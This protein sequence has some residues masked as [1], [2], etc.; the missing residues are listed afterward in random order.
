MNRLPDPRRFGTGSAHALLESVAAAVAAADL[1]RRARRDALR[2]KLRTLLLAGDE[3]GIRQAFA[4]MPDAAHFRTLFDA[5]AQ[6]VESPQTDAQSVQLRLFAFPLVLV[7]AAAATIRIAGVLPRIADV[8]QLFETSAVLGQMRN[9]GLSAALCSLDALESVSPVMLFAAERA[10]DADAVK[11]HLPPAGLE[12]GAGREQAHLRFL[13]GA[14][15]GR[16]D[17]PEF[18]ETAAN[19][20]AWGRRLGALIAQQLAAPGLQL[21]V[22]PRMPAGLMRVRHA[23]RCAQLDVA[24]HLF[25]SNTV[26]RMRMSAGEPAAILSTHDSGELRLTLSSVF[27]DDLVESFRWP[28][29]PLDDLGAVEQAIVGLLRE[30]RIDDVRVVPSVLPAKRASGGEWHPRVAE[31]DTLVSGAARH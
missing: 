16:A 30:V 6:A 4:A 7:A 23:G 25:V 20:G 27:A 29:A 14:G 2:S 9:F 18:S 19:I 21:L 17:A 3:A 22:L 26:R 24:L 28:L 13:V 10:I 8:Q 5:L 11:L 12:I 31:W 15:I 1:D